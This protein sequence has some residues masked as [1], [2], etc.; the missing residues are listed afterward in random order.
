MNALQPV[1]ALRSLVDAVPTGQRGRRRRRVWRGH[2]RAHIEVRGASHPGWR[3][4]LDDV[5]RELAALRG[6]SWAEVNPVLARVVVAFDDR[7]LDLPDLLGVVEGVEAAHGVHRE[8]FP[9]DRPEHP[10]DGE[11]LYR[12]VLAVAADVGALVAGS[13]ARRLLPGPLPVEA[14]AVFPL[15]DALPRLR[16]ELSSRFGEAATDLGLAVGG[17]I[18]QGLTQGPLG[19]LVDVTQR[20]LLIREAMAREQA[21]HLREPQLV[22]TDDGSPL[23]PLVQPPRPAPLPDGP[24]ERHADRAAALGLAAAA[25]TAVH[26]TRGARSRP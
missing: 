13:V 1:S 21:W 3:Q 18:G 2:G 14:A 17:A 4:L 19:L 9:Y 26:V 16:S 11:P 6:V 25:M 12:Q 23:L 7:E 5:E 8:R 15:V 24:I 20:V 22:V 10:G